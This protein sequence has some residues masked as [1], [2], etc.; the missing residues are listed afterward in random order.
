MK[1]LDYKKLILD[2]EWYYQGAEARP[3]Y[4]NIPFRSSVDVSNPGRSDKFSV[5]LLHFKDDFCDIYYDKNGMNRISYA[6][7]AAQK[8]DT[9]TL[10]QIYSS[11]IHGIKSFTK[12]WVKP[13]EINKLSDEALLSRFRLLCSEA[14][15]VWDSL[16]FIDAF[17]LIS[18]SIIETAFKRITGISS[19]EKEI[20]TSP[21]ELA[22]TQR[23]K[24]S[25]LKVALL[26]KK[27]KEI[28]KLLDK[29]S[30]LFYWYKNN[31][32]VIE[33][34][35]AAYF[36]DKMNNISLEHTYKQIKTE[37]AAL[38]SY[39]KRINLKKKKILKKHS[40]SGDI[41]DT[42]NFFTT[43]TLLRDRRKEWMLKYHVLIK[44][45]ASE[46]S[47]R[48]KIPHH[49]LEYFSYWEFGSF[50][51]LK[52]INAKQRL[53]HSTWIADENSG[54]HGIFG[55]KALAINDLLQKKLI[56][57][58][59]TLTG[60]SASSGF[61]IGTVKIINRVSE[62]SKMQQG[63]IL[64]SSNTRP[65]YVPVMKKA[66]AIITDEGGITCHAAI[67]S[68]ELRIPCIVGTQVATKTL[69]DGMRVEVDA[70]N[71]LVRIINP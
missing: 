44:Q 29:H 53:I 24:L 9:G 48:T 34:L 35:D 30:S 67:V 5:I 32:S 62:F 43:L 71:G 2:N 1:N 33:S 12:R 18:D 4:I 16:L 57:K 11:A 63:D 22:F 7:L 70:D 64:V 52:K 40:F 50:E 19:S 46:I 28:G 49:E 36:R 45:F 14:Q 66:A 6:I 47:V 55:K 61:A 59:E 37:I 20:L 17:D 25:L 15:K 23:E 39:E 54:Y 42:L 58:S 41:T 51:A 56:N 65:E 31:Y 10:T 69:K 13:M 3:L 27:G 26:A 60:V 38:E 8:R 68:R 21:D